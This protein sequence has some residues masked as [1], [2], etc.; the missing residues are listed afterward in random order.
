L[1]GNVNEIPSAELCSG[2]RGAE[3]RECVASVP[4]LETQ[5]SSQ[6]QR[7]QK[8]GQGAG[9]NL[10]FAHQLVEMAREGLHPV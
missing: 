8:Y 7:V 4:R 3:I 9:G 6:R 10:G 1:G 2:L 5:F